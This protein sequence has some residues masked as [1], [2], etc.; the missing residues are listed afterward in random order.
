M[1]YIGKQPTKI[2]LDGSDIVDGSITNDDLAGS[3]TSAKI[4][5]LDAAKLLVR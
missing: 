4:T 2:P 3:I 5:S 1:P